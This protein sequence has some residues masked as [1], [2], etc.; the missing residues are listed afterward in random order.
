M[1]YELVRIS[2]F[3]MTRFCQP[4]ASRSTDLYMLLTF[5]NIRDQRFFGLTPEAPIQRKLKMWGDGFL[6]LAG[7]WYADGAYRHYRSCA[8]LRADES[9]L[10][11][12][13]SACSA[14]VQGVMLILFS[15]VACVIN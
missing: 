8:Q 13:A 12:A 14:P 3:F 10:R 7:V 6:E 9:L 15:S 4:V 5:A 1:I 2:R 11:T